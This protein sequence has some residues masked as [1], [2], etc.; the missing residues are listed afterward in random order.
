MAAVAWVIRNRAQWDEEIAPDHPE[1]EWWGVSVATV[2]MHP[3]QFSCW[4]GGADTLR[5]MNLKNYDPEYLAAEAVV[6]AVMDGTIP[7]PTGGATTYKVRGTP[8]RWDKAVA[9]VAPRS[10][11]AHDFWRLSPNGP[12]LAFLDEP[13]T[14]AVA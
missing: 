12:C 8:A 1:H 10:I 3:Y 5:I 6:R 9:G 13:L 7:D 11:G 2:C 4:L 14:Q